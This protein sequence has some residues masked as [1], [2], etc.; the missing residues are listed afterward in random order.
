MCFC[1]IREIGFRQ[2]R[3]GN[4]RGATLRP[5]DHD[6]MM[7]T[8]RRQRNPFGE[9]VIHV[10]AGFVAKERPHVVETLSTL[11]PHLGRWD[12]RE[13]DIDV[14]LQNRGG[15]EQSI[16]L[17][18]KLPGLP[19][20]VAVAENTDVNRALSEA[21][22]ELIRQFERQKSAREPMTNRRLSRATIRHPGASA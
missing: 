12:P 10:S 2:L 19:P 7:K 17:R 1:S 9:N 3:D 15:N 20:L 4:A 11:G 21:K 13:V 8:L 22:R 16:T 18:M 6:M 14:S 5:K